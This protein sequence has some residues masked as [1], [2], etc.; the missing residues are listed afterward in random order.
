MKELFVLLLV[1]SLSAGTA[2][3]LTYNANPTVVSGADYSGGS[4]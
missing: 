4:W 2:A 1:M 3:A